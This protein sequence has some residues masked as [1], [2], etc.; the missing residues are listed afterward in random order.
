MALRYS[1]DRGDLA[2]AV[3]HAV[4][5]VLADGLRTADIMSEG[6][7][8][9]KTAEMGDALIRSLQASRKAA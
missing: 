9:V 8:E 1:F 4:Q 2:D 6:C 7:T 5:N 3:E